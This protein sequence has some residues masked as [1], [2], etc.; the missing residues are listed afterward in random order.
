MIKLFI[1]GRTLTS[2]F[3]KMTV[4]LCCFRGVHYNC[5]LQKFCERTDYFKTEK[6]CEREQVFVS[7]LDV[8]QEGYDIT[9]SL[10]QMIVDFIENF[11]VPTISTSNAVPILAICNY[12][13]IPHLKNLVKIYIETHPFD[14]IE[15]FLYKEPKECPLIYE[16]LIAHHLTDYVSNPVLLNFPIPSLHRIFSK[17]AKDGKDLCTEGIVDLVCRGL[18]KY[19]R[20]FSVIATLIP[21]GTSPTTEKYF[22]EKMLD[23]YNDKF[24]PV[25]LH[26]S[27]LK[28]LWDLS[29]GTH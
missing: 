5:S 7:I 6:N 4:R 17:F 9:E 19:G 25:F 10:V 12:L 28:Y 14:I 15:E 18:D 11:N 13:Q 29:K 22:L 2:F 24:D 21:V 27:H 16:R 1:H 23:D 20:N 3:I 8:Q 26:P